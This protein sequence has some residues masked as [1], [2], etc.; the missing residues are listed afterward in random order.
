MPHPFDSAHRGARPAASPAARRSLR[1]AAA[2]LA[3]L[4]IPLLAGCSQTVPFD[5][6]PEASDTACADVVVRLPDAVADLAKRETNA[7]G[8]GAWGS[9][10][11]VLLRCG[12]TPPG[13]TTDRCVTVDGVDWVIDE[14][15][16]P[17]YR[18]TTYGRTPAVEVV[19]DGDAV[20][21][22]TAITDLASAVSAIPPGDGCVGAD[23][24]DLDGTAG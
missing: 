7:Q 4:T 3:A 1:L 10:A 14:T 16:A 15:D 22:T 13:P 6:A 12:V 11:V 9:P 20:S 19:V 8:T 23:E 21:G 24:L 5:A 18:F 2:G 17:R